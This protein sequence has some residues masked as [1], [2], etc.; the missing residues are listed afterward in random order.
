[1]V[2]I[3]IQKQ[4]KKYYDDNAENW[5]KEKTNSF[6]HEKRFPLFRS[7]L[8]KGNNVIDIGCAWGIHVPLFMG[9]GSDLHYTGLDFS[10]K[11]I[12]IA[13]RRFPNQTFVNGDITAK[14]TLP[15][16]KYDAFWMGA[17]LM[18]IPPQDW[19]TVFLNL[20][21]LT[22]SGAIGYI[23]FPFLPGDAQQDARH[24]TFLSKKEFK[25]EVIKHGWKVVR[26]GKINGSARHF[27]N[28]FIIKKAV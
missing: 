3:I 15:H 7:M 9:M 4:N 23:S 20:N 13:K 28:W 5:T 1:M 8:E 14:A 16:K 25:D 24:F 22:K 18:H 17:I 2:D 21:T 19:S 26:S 10:K 6:F 11:M 27:W 12:S